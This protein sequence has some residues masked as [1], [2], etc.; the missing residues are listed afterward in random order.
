MTK[1]RLI[2]RGST[3]RKCLLVSIL[4][5]SVTGCAADV[6]T[7]GLTP[8][9]SHAIPARRLPAEL[10]GAQRDATVPIDF[11]YLRQERPAEHVIGHGDV[12]GVYVRDVLDGGGLAP[13]H[14]PLQ[15]DSLIESP[16]VGQPI[17]VQADG[18]VR[19]P[20]VA[21]VRVAGLTLS[22]AADVIRR[23]YVMGEVLQP[24]RAVVFVDLIRP[25]TVKVVVL[26][27]DMGLSTPVLKS[28]DTHL[29]G[30]HGS[31]RSVQLPIFENDV[32]HAL[33]ATGGLPGQDAYNAVWILRG[34]ATQDSDYDAVVQRIDGG[35]TSFEVLQSLAGNNP[36]LR[37][38]L[39][40]LDHEQPSID[41]ADV[42]LDEGDIVFIES[43]EHEF[44][45]TGGLLTGGMFPLPR[46]IDLDIF[47]AI[48]LASGNA[49][50]PAGVNAA[51]TNFNNRPGNIVPP[52]RVIII[53]SLPDG[54][55]IKIHVDLRVAVNN[56]RERLVI[57]PRDVVLLKYRPSELLGNLALNLVSLNYFIPNGQ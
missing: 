45:V 42:I 27:E 50:G 32:L 22:A 29:V 51:A 39:R 19:L 47:G 31:A 23:S 7:S 20:D 48:A 16:S 3:S 44:F 9:A 43:R 18:S 4:A 37:I 41:P 52:T 1:T 21:P 36:L 55:Q 33:T 46:D 10:R 8:I 35:E 53:R 11:R 49:T 25:R 38:P 28:R 30:Q 15:D 5:V 40:C 6:F 12:L 2:R 13:V 54:Q 57:Q 24:E 34:A 17:R 26:R 56:P 14:Y